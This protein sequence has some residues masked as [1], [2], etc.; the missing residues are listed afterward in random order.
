MPLVRECDPPRLGVQIWGQIIL[1]LEAAPVNFV[2]A[3]MIVMRD[4]SLHLLRGV[5]ELTLG[6][7]LSRWLFWPNMV[8]LL[9]EAVFLACVR[10]DPCVTAIH[11]R[12]IFV[13]S[14]ES[15]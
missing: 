13:P 14:L 1:P 3:D 11:S 4:G 2:R 5:P 6:I 7:S 10:V 12:D 9:K 8:A 15:A